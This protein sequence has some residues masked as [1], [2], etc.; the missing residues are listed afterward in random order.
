MNYGVFQ[1]YYSAEIGKTIHLKGNPSVTGLIGTTSNGVMYLSMPLF[2]LMLTAPNSIFLRHRRTSAIFGTVVMCMSL[3]LSSYSTHVWHLVATQGVLA[4]LGAAFVYSP[5]TLSQGEWFNNH[6]RAVAYGVTLGCKNVVGSTCP[7]LLRAMLDRLGLRMTL[8][9]WSAIVAGT[10]ILAI[11]LVPTHPS[12]LS[13]T[14]RRRPRRVPYFF[15]KHGMFYVYAAS[16]VLQS[17]GYGIPQ[18]YLNTY[19]HE[20]MRLS[21]S[22]ATLMLTL[23]NTPGIIACVCFGFLTDNKR[24]HLSAKSTTAISAIA[25]SSSAFLFWGLTSP[26]DGGMTLLVFFSITFGF[27]ASGYSATWGGMINEL[28]SQAS[29]LNEA[30]DTGLA[31]G[32][33]NGARGIGYVVGGV[34]SVSL[35]KSGADNDEQKWGYDTGYGAL[36]IL[37]ALSTVFGGLDFCLRMGQSTVMFV[38]R[39]LRLG[40]CANTRRAAPT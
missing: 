33:L 8:K 32:L 2:F 22:S 34:A 12:R 36:I 13:T 37:T 20:V 31:Y 4:A 25:S 29:N 18:T 16:I 14:E 24:F 3:L 26:R 40:A 23:F 38:M 11:F 17:L 9:V 27:F 6:N 30:I 35:L 21:Q 15:L 5:L 19:A 28:E 1:E 7:F 39:T 10:S